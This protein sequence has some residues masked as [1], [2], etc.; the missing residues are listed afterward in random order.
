MHSE[1]MEDD[2]I[3]GLR[4]I[5]KCRQVN[6]RNLRVIFCLLV[7]GGFV[8]VVF[9]PAVLLEVLGAYLYWYSHIKTARVRCPRCNEAFGSS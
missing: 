7:V 8:S 4:H 1:S 5:Q 6:T 2:Y 3:E 9:P